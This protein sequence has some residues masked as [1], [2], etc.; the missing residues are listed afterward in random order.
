MLSVLLVWCLIEKGIGFFLKIYFLSKESGLFKYMVR[1]FVVGILI[2]YVIVSVLVLFSVI[3]WLF[4][5]YW[6]FLLLFFDGII[7]L[8]W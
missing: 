1:F 7:L 3:M 4:F 5:I 6:I 2:F 8:Y